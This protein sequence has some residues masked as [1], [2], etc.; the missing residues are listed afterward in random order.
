LVEALLGDGRRTENVVDGHGERTAD[1]AVDAETIGAGLE[2]GIAVDD[3]VDGEA[4]DRGQLG[5]EAELGNRGLADDQPTD[6]DAGQAE[7]GC[8]PDPVGLHCRL[9]RRAPH[10]VHDY[11]I[12]LNLSLR[13]I[14]PL[15]LRMVLLI[16]YILVAEITGSLRKVYPSFPAGSVGAPFLDGCPA[17]PLPQSKSPLWPYQA[18]ACH[19]S[20]WH[21]AC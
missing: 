14:Y 3:S 21:N 5:H 20:L 16:G 11:T 10:A 2:R 15:L 7:K 6:G 9:W 1:H 12:S 17:P 18:I 4:V 13:S 19:G 8:P